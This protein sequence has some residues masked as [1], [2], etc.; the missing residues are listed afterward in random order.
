MK[1]KCGNRLINTVVHDTNNSIYLSVEGTEE[2]TMRNTLV[3]LKSNVD[4]I[5]FRHLVT[6]FH[7][8]FQKS[9]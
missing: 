6:I 2:K 7:M 3:R 5:I 4:N 1:A 8:I 9:S